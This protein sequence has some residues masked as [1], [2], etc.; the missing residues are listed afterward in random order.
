MIKKET[1][2]SMI[3]KLGLRNTIIAVFIIAFIGLSKYSQ[4]H[5]HVFI[6]AKIQVHFDKSGLSGFNVSWT[7]DNMFSELMIDE[8]DTDFDDLLSKDEQKVIY[9]KAFVN[10]KKFGYF[11][12]IRIN[13]KAFDIKYVANFSAK[14]NDGILSYS[15]FIPCHTPIQSSD[16]TIEVYTYDNSYYMDVSLTNSSVS[17]TNSTPY[18]IGSE[19]VEDESKRY[20]FEQ[21]APF[22]LRMKIHRKL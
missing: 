6:D 19:V 16:K 3:N 17:F 7:F 4:A 5:P 10:L 11:T 2:E 13:G 12:E 15:F 22:V 8:F 1:F 20:Y 21:I 9:Q 18:Q 14:N